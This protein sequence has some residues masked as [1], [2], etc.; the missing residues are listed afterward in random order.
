MKNGM[1]YSPTER[2]TPKPQRRFQGT[3]SQKTIYN[4]VMEKI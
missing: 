1:L 2:Q 4:L 3:R